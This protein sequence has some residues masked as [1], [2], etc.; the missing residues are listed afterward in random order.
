MTNKLPAA[1]TVCT[2]RQARAYLV[3]LCVLAALHV[4]EKSVLTFE[5]VCTIP[6]H[7]YEAASL[8]F[9]AST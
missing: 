5:W 3:R 7:A 1:R 6:M 9:D 2:S 4:L 8:N